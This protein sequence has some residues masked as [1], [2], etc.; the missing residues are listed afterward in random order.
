MA[1][2]IKFMNEGF[3]AKYGN[4]KPDLNES[5]DSARAYDISKYCLDKGYDTDQALR[6][7]K[8]QMEKE[9][10]KLPD[11]DKEIMEVIYSVYDDID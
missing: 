5:W 1:N 3:D 10:S 9:G 6:V 4:I 8:R 7:V 2:S 11:N